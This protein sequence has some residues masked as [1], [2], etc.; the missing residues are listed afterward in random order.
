[1]LNRPFISSEFSNVATVIDPFTKQNIAKN[2]F[3]IERV[4]LVF[5]LASDILKSHKY[6]MNNTNIGNIVI[7]S[8]LKVKKELENYT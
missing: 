1:M 5:A 6:L 8:I 7:D 4:K 3:N 2:S